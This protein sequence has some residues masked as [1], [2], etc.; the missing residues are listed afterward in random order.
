MFHAFVLCIEFAGEMMNKNWMTY[1]WNWQYGA[2]FQEKE[3]EEEE[4]SSSV[5]LKHNVWKKKHSWLKLCIVSI[6]FDAISLP[7]SINEKKMLIIELVAFFHKL[8][9]P[10]FSYISRYKGHCVCGCMSDGVSLCIPIYWSRSHIRTH[11]VQCTR[12]LFTLI[13]QTTLAFVIIPFG[14]RLLPATR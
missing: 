8:K 13:G 4:S 5:L 3:E 9:I 6:D 7:K 12:A 14:A 1:T 2:R 11:A 10:R